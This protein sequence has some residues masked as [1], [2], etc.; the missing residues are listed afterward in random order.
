MQKV[1]L[2]DCKYI[3]IHNNFLTEITQSCSFINKFRVV[4]SQMKSIVRRYGTVIYFSFSSSFIPCL[5]F[6]YNLLLLQSRQSNTGT[7]SLPLHWSHN[8]IKSQIQ[9]TSFLN[10]EMEL[11]QPFPCTRRKTYGSSYS[12]QYNKT[13]KTQDIFL[14]QMC[15]E[16]QKCPTA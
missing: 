5:L 10:L 4:K 8:V 3:Y 11:E 16:S 1:Q 7:I 9:A 2:Y 13:R 12:K 6:L 15:C 14:R